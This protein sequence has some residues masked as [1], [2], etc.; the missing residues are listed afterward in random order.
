MLEVILFEFSLTLGCLLCFF[1]LAKNSSLS[2]ACIFFIPA[3][4]WGFFAEFFGI[5]LFHMYFYQ[6]NYFL[7]IFDV[8]LSIA[9]GWAMMIYIGYFLV[10]KKFN[11]SNYFKIG[12]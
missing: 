11:V 2:D 5:N 10:A 1:H 9:I 3:I 7:K 12:F 4:L 8:P 6:N